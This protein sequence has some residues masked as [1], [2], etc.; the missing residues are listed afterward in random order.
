ML[1]FLSIL[2][3]TTSVNDSLGKVVNYSS[4]RIIYYPKEER[5][6][7]INSAQVQ[8]REVIINADSILYF[9]NEK[10]LSAYKNVIFISGSDKVNGDELHYNL[11]TKRGYM[12][13]GKTTVENGFVNGREVWLV[14]EKVLHIRDGYYTTCE[15]EPPHYLFYSPRAR[16]LLDNT[17]IAQ[18]IVLKVFKVPIGAAPF[19]FFPIS[20]YRKSGLLPFKFGQSN[21][22]GRYAK[23]IAYYLVINDYADI[24]FML[25]VM[26]KKGFQP[27]I[28]GIYIVNPFASGQIFASYI[29]ELQTKRQRYSINMKHRSEFI[30]GSNLNAYIDY[31]SDNSYLPDYAEN[32]VQWLKKEI[33]S[34]V[35]LSR[36]IT[37]M[38]RTNLVIEHKRDFENS[39]TDWKL[40]SLSVSLQRIG[41]TKNWS[42]AS[43]INYQHNFKSFDS[44]SMRNRKRLYNSE[45]LSGRIN[46]SNPK[47]LLGVFNLPLNVSYRQVKDEYVDSIIQIREQI[48]VSSS[49][50][51][52]QNVWQTLNFS[53]AIGFEQSF[54]KRDS[55]Q[56]KYS[57]SFNSNLTLFRL[58]TVNRL[59]LE[60][61]LHRLSPSLSFNLIPKTE[62]YGI[63]V[64]PRFDKKSELAD[65]SF[66]VSNLWQ[67]KLQANDEKRDLAVISLN[68]SYN[69][70]NRTFAPLSIFSDLY[71]V[72]T[73]NIS[74]VSNLNMVMRYFNDRRF[75][76][77]ISDLSFNTSFNYTIIKN[78]TNQGSEQF[79]TLGLN[80]NLV[81]A[82]NQVVLTLQSNMLNLVVSVIPKGWRFD[83]NSGINF[84]EKQK[85]TNYS[86]TIYKDL[87]CWE[88]IFDFNKFGA[89]WAYDFKVRIKKIPDI[90]FSK[91]ILNFVLPF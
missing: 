13:N 24:T 27:K 74:L 16:V 39:M 6:L 67:G 45:F 76:L 83:F 15:H 30:L 69:L 65:L 37:R 19:W 29:R 50:A 46:F 84:K 51:T 58:F 35:S 28:E 10:S 86:L 79:F 54:F 49:F 48:N 70:T 63:L 1:I 88:A 64:L 20:K 78:D 72:R 77:K 61:V 90:S 66:T 7:L 40:P 9:L 44:S 80:H 3:F 26:E 60:N 33:Y 71:M 18:G 34:Q 17:A 36:D 12:I 75:T 73:E 14:K 11:D 68:S 21:S 23:G 56:A 4:E 32:P 8:Y 91:N 57:F 2:L 55:S 53:E 22:D 41:L 43:G 47:T 5:V 59:G 25:D 42:F 85:I 89:Q 81:Y 62:P 31:Q 52:T 38:L 87:H 82:R